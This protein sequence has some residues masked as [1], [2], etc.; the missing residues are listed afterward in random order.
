MSSPPGVYVLQTARNIDAV[1]SFR[2]ERAWLDLVGSRPYS[3]LHR[4][5]TF[6]T[7]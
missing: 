7:R 4:L 2:T 1:S 6:S 3:R 5:S